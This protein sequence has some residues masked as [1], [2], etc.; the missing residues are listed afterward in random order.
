MKRLLFVIPTLRMGGAERSL[1]SLLNALDPAR[2]QV[3][4]LLFEA[5]GVLQSQL[6]DWVNVLESDPVTRGMILEIRYHLKEAAKRSL[7]A[8]A[9]RL[10]MTVRSKLG[11]KL[12]LPPKFSWDIVKK[13]VPKL[14]K[15]YDA[16]IGYL[17]GFTDFYVIDKVDADRKIGWIHT[18]ISKTRHADKEAA[19]YAKFDKLVTITEKCR[20]A[21]LDRY[22]AF[23]GKTIVIHNLVSADEVRQKAE[24]SIETEKTP[25]VYE[26]VT[27]GRLEYAKGID[28]AVETGRILAERGFP[29]RW[30]VYGDGSLRE[31]IE[32]KIE[33]L[34]LEE[35]MILHGTVAN[36]YPFIKAAD[37]IV[38]PSRWEGKSVLLDEAKL[39]GKAI[40]VT[41]YPSVSDQV[42]HGETG[43]IVDAKPEA[44]ADGIE[45]VLHD[46]VLRAHLEKN[47]LETPDKT[48][49]ILK[50]FY[51]M[52]GE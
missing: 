6:P 33:A 47:C 22:P 49:A 35:K 30:H 1:V 21:I 45:H 26:L 36:P 38:Q 3:D 32:K 15:R 40:V 29:F 31:E 2:V 27:V 18:D 46:T 14:K 28:I 50:I 7:P 17:E 41:N 34:G 5:G 25:D 42:C 23:E 43:W 48:A 4:L 24:E 52:I 20:D 39:L 13:H 9:A 44:I 37:V 51:R 12:N 16:A 10:W 11:Q 8:A 19:Y